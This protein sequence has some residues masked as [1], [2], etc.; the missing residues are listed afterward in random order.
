MD[1]SALD[2]LADELREYLIA[3]ISEVGG[4]LAAGLGTVELAVALHY[5]FHT[6]EDRLVWDIGHQAYPHKI[7][8]GRKDALPTIR[9]HGGLSGFLRRGESEFDTFGAGHA[10]T[11]ISAALG[12]AAAAH[13][14]TV[15]R[16]VVAI[17]GDGAL[18]AGEP[19]EALNNAGAMDTDLLV[20]LNDNEMSISRNV[21][22]LSNYLARILS[23]RTYTT[24]RAGSKTVL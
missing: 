9:Q 4:H 10:G 12:M 23:G 21:G 13:L 7:L 11:S 8:T 20:I 5:V 17:I 2:E 1:E 16:Q 3:V 22:A 6:P 19:M 15:E 24:V 18:T 14:D